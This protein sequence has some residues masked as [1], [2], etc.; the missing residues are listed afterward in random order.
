MA[1]AFLTPQGLNRQAMRSEPSS[2]PVVQ[3]FY[4]PASGSF[5]PVRI[6]RLE[7]AFAASGAR[8]LTSPSVSEPPVI[9]Q[10]ATHAC[11][12]GGDG[13]VRHV[14]MAMARCGRALPAAIWPAGTV[15]LLAREGPDCASPER[16]AAD[17]LGASERREHWPVQLGETMFLACASVGPDARAVAGVSGALKRRI[18]RLAYVVSFVSLLRRWP[19]D[20]LT[21]EADGRT[22]ACEAVFVAKGRH[23]AGPWSFAPRASVSDGLLHVIALHTARRRDFARFILDLALGRDPARRAGVTAFVTRRLSIDSATALPVQADGDVVAR[24]PVRLAVAEA[25]LHFR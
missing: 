2:Q 23:Y 19:R 4:N 6:A 13:T 16:L 21:L 3:L 9:A 14:A 10:D 1:N 17:L 12:A 24:L 25:P 20:V 5:D 8:V 18:G 7:R 11:I 15:N 22:L